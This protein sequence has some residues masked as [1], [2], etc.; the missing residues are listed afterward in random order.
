MKLD[1]TDEEQN[2]AVVIVEDDPNVCY[3]F[4][5]TVKHGMGLRRITSFIE[6][7]EAL[8]YFQHHHRDVDVVL[9]DL[10]MPE[11]DGVQVLTRLSEIDPNIQVLVVSAYADQ[12]SVVKTLSLLGL[13]ANRMITKPVEPEA[14]AEVLRDAYRVSRTLRF[15]EI[16]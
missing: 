1:W 12:K 15:G 14:L 9:L 16:R 3:S 13:P 11:I 5:F 7:A 6:P 10:N 4:E 2:M 8:A